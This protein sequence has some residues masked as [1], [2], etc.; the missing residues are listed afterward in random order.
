MDQYHKYVNDL[1]MATN[2][3]AAKLFNAILYLIFAIAIRFSGIHPERPHKISIELK[4]GIEEDLFHS[5]YETASK[6]SLE[7]QSLESTQ[8]W[9][10]ITFSL[11]AAHRQTSSYTSLGLLVECVKECCSRLISLLR[12][13]GTKSMKRSKPKGCSG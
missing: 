10:L 11:R 8:S 9:V 2:A 3:K 12:Q 4:P 1:I 7:W 13:T 6:L 5:A